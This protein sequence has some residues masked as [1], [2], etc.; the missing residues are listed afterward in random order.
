M[1]IGSSIRRLRRQRSINQGNL[2]KNLGISA[3]YLNLIENNKRNV[4]GDLLV[5]LRY[6][7]IFVNKVVEAAESARAYKFY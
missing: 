1:R 3:S 5:K 7:N 6:Y 4:T 2:A